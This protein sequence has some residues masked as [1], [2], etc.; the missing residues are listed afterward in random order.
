MKGA[1]NAPLICIGVFALLG[2]AYSVDLSPI[3]RVVKLLQDLGKQIERESKQEEKMFEEY[4]CW[5]K[6]IVD[7]KTASNSAAES[8]IDMLK[9]YLADIDAGRVEFTGERAALEKAIADAMSDIENANALRKKENGEFLEAS[10]EM[11]QAIDALNQAITILDDATKDHKEGVLLAVRASL[12]GAARNGGMAQLVERQA[13][14]KQAV[15]LGDRFLSK[16]DATFLRRVLLGEVPKPDWKKL[17]RKATF[18]MNYKARSFKIQGVLKEMLA[19]FRSN[20]KDAEDDEAKAVA[21]HEELTG[22]K[23]GNA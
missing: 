6:K 2:A 18:K 1:S 4:I 21:A 20:L 16:G 14:L 9:Q 3:S 12:N 11:S 19:T 5:G 15:K 23:T 10:K 13:S 22:K 7:T 8:R 17:N